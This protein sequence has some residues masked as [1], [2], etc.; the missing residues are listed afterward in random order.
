MIS[1]GGFG[2]R[3]LWEETM[4]LMVARNR[5][6]S[7]V[8]LPIN[9]MMGQNL[10]WEWQ[11]AKIN[12]Y[13]KFWL[14]GKNVSAHRVSYQLTKGPIPDGMKI[15]HLCDNPGCCNP[16]H[17]IPGTTQDNS[18]DMISRGRSA[19]GEEVG[20]SFLTETQVKE[21][22]SSPLGPTDLARKYHV[23]K[24]TISKIKLGRTWGHVQL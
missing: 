19:K 20:A 17:L 7:K 16:R 6:W 21:I 9:S 12:G 2:P 13:G 11:G 15:L 1:D 14:D 5:F 3:C 10:C 8:A 22:K 4:S 18:D 24:S 23:T